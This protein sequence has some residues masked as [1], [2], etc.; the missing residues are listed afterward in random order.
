MNFPFHASIQDQHFVLPLTVENDSVLFNVAFSQVENV[1][2][3][4]LPEN[5]TNGFILAKAVRRGFVLTKQAGQT[6]LVDD[7]E[8]LIKTYYLKTALF[9]LTRETTQDK[10]S[11]LYWAIRIYRQ[12]Q[13]FLDRD[14]RIPHFFLN[15]KNRAD[16]ECLFNCDDEPRH[17]KAQQHRN[18][19]S[20]VITCISFLQ[21]QV[22]I[23]KK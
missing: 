7:F 8:Q 6:Q 14:R 10:K 1:I 12:L 21:Q 19:L 3:A 4:K 11:R 16:G 9:F 15:P 22:Y 23:I 17:I 2:V 20:A 13:T 5:I 18:M